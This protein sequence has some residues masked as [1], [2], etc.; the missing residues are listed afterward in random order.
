MR[1]LSATELLGAWER[2]LGQPRLQQALTLLAAAYPEV[3]P[4]ALAN[5]SIGQRDAR[6]MELRE[7]TFGANFTGLANCPA[8]NETVELAFDTSAVR[9][10]EAMETPAELD[11]EVEGRKLH[12]RLPTS[13]DLFAVTTR[14]QLLDRCLLGG[15]DQL[16]DQAIDSVIAQ[17]ARADPLADIQLALHC[18]SCG[19][20]WE[21]NFDIVT[22]LWSE[23]N[24][25]ARNLLRGIH[26]L[27]SAYGWS[28]A[29]ILALNPARRRLYLEMVN[30]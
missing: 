6:L 29:D 28:E 22:F 30:R 24:A 7:L 8:C 16:P 15:R 17:M 13:A 26:A 25:A 12:F 23:I 4:E 18:A 2:G 14:D 5:L 10:A 3:P 21:A 1:A 19:H 27:A 11:A 9:P 20:Q